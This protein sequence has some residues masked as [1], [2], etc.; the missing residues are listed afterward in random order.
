MNTSDL[1]Y[2]MSAK[3]AL[4]HQALRA[5][6]IA[7]S[8][9]TPMPDLHNIEFDELASMPTGEYDGEG[10]HTL[11][12]HLKH[13]MK[14]FGEYMEGGIRT[15]RYEGEGA[16]P[17]MGLSQFRGGCHDMART[18]GSGKPRLLLCDDPPET[19]SDSKGHFRSATAPAPVRKS[20]AKMKV[21]H[22]DTGFVI[23]NPSGKGKMKGG[24]ERI[25]L[26]REPPAALADSHGTYA[27]RQ[28]RGPAKPSEKRSSRMEIVKKVMA[29]RGVGLIEASKI[30]KAE[31]LY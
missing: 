2:A 22:S 24:A 23:T 31:A 3:R 11:F 12:D 16:T 5:N 20:K 15:G 18:V 19:Y 7:P 8:F 4:E 26:C 14:G 10:K 17:S 25:Q 30:V 1:K 28:K 27:R 6:S 9:K 21:E 13:P 29:E